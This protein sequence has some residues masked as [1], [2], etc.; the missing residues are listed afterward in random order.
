MPSLSIRRSL[1]RAVGA[2]LIVALAACGGGGIK[3]DPSGKFAFVVNTLGNTVSAYT[4]H[5]STGALTAVPGSPF[6]AGTTPRS[7]TVDPSGK[8]AYAASF[9]SNNV[10]V[11]NIEATTG[12][13]TGVDGLSVSTGSPM[14]IALTR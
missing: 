8:F 12:A 3:V 1:S 6:E 14:S 5:P 9:D 10:S 4:I 11:Y 13:L 7:V 2:A